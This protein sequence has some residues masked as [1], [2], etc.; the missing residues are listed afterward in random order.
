M[1]TWEH[2]ATAATYTEAQKIANRNGY[3][4]GKA[5]IDSRIKN[6]DTQEHRIYVKVVTK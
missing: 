2:I 3:Y 5:R 6:D 1:T 4:Q